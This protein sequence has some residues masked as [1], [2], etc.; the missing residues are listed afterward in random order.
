MLSAALGAAAWAWC[1]Q[2]IPLVLVPAVA[3]ASDPTLRSVESSDDL[4]ALERRLVALAAL[5]RPTQVAVRVMDDSGGGSCS[6]TV[7]DA[8]EGWILTAGHCCGGV[9]L[10]VQVQLADGRTIPGKTAGYCFDGR[11]D[12]GLIKVDP[13]E[14]LTAAALGDSSPLVPGDWLAPFGHTHGYMKDRPAVLRV[15]RVLSQRGQ[16]IDVDAPLSGGD[17]GG[18]VFDVQGHLV[19]VV[20]TTANE[21]TFGTICTSEFVLVKLEAM[22]SGTTLGKAVPRQQAPSARRGEAV[23]F[24]ATRGQG[25]SAAQLCEVIGEVGDESLQ[26]VC[27]VHVDQRPAG[28][29]TVLSDDGVLLAKDSAIGS[30]SKDIVVTLPGGVTTRAER[31]LRDRDLDLVVLKVSGSD[32][33]PVSW[34]AQSVVPSGSILISASP[35]WNAH[36]WGV[37]SLDALRDQTFDRL[38]GYLGIQMVRGEQAGAGVC[39]EQSVRGSPA[40]V[41]GV[42]AGDT[43]VRVAGQEIR[44]EGDI[45]RIARAYGGGELLTIDVLRDGVPLALVTR[46]TTRPDDQRIAQSTSQFPA[47]RRSSGFGPILQHDTPLPGTKLGGPLLNLDG[48]AVAVNIARPD[49]TA[50]YAI[51]ASVLRALAPQWIEAAR[52]GTRLAPSDPSAEWPR[53]PRELDVWVGHPALADLA[54][55]SLVYSFDG[56]SDAG[57]VVGWT[58]PLARIAWVADLPVGHYDAELEYALQA[59][60]AESATIDIGIGER[61]QRVT[62]LAN[63]E[64]A[65]RHSAPTPGTVTAK[66][67]VV[68]EPGVKRVWVGRAGA[69]LAVGRLRLRLH[70][71]EAPTGDPN[72]D[73]AN[74]DHERPL[75]PTVP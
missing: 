71:S 9:G 39:V 55:P 52:A 73:D 4:R 12:C 16:S 13:A 60:T 36:A 31:V 75:A 18:G 6:G 23:E 28:V 22:K 63:D 14:R 62:V 53:M 17:S 42:R 25:R 10:D 41:G 49:R 38:S 2:A 30:A 27:A 34:S 67:L 69:P 21:P 43:I 47:S 33:V 37:S 5:A 48:E 74:D 54:G 8:A 44:K 57:V 15:G 26:S 32:L 3:R 11:A 51:P 45:G 59:R 29:A 61:H 35:T 66:G 20:S 68:T 19:G 70:Q 58:E 64:S 7:I 1:V 50:T 72:N 56:Q 65:D 24:D 40:W 46:A